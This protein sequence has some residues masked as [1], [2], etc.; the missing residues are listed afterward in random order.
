M[1]GALQ[2]KGNYGVDGQGSLKVQGMQGIHTG[3]NS[4]SNNTQQA[5]N[6]KNE[7]MYKQ[8]GRNQKGRIQKERTWLAWARAEALWQYDG[9]VREARVQGVCLSIGWII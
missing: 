8:K 3:C 7:V 4:S 2:L 1:A 5:H 6:I 9:R